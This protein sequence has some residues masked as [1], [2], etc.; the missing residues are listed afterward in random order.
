MNKNWYATKF[1]HR[2]I[3]W[4]YGHRLVFTLSLSFAFAR[5]R[6]HFHFGLWMF[7][8][9]MWSFNSFV[10]IAWHC[11]IF[12]LSFSRSLSFSIFLFLF[13]ISIYL[14][15]FSISVYLFLFHNRSQQNRTDFNQFSIQ[16]ALKLRKMCGK[17]FVLT[18]QWKI[19]AFRV[20]EYGTQ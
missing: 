15:L 2:P 4:N 6:F 3:Y 5:Y 8:I 20:E 9:G 17:N 10:P 1:S 16:C 12:F 14:F 7:V 11:S 18:F 19:V 13:S